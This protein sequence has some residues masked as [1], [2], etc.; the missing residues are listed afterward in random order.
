MRT[1]MLTVLIAVLALAG[2]AQPPPGGEGGRGGREGRQAMDLS[3]P[4]EG[5]VKELGTMEGPRDKVTVVTITV[6]TAKETVKIILA[7]QARLDKLGLK[8]AVGTAVKVVAMGSKDARDKDLRFAREIT[9]AGKT[10]RMRPSEVEGLQAVTVTGVVK[11]ILLP[12]PP[13]DAPKPDAAAKPEGGDRPDRQ[14]MGMRPVEVLLETEKGLV[15]VNL[16][17]APQLKN[18]G[19]TPAEGQKLTVTGWMR[20][21]KTRPT[22]GKDTP[23]AAPADAPKAAVMIIARTVTLDGKILTLRDEDGRFIRPQRP[24][25]EG[26]N[27]RQGQR[28][29]KK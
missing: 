18:L 3:V 13:P 22:A 5:T 25:G 8:L 29:E 7:P 19:L 12:Q 28:G 16:A 23:K 6:T 27:A 24:A 20:E 10:Y 21:I 2:V 17:P 11:K 15:I 9:V 26:R 1:L 14:R 4:V